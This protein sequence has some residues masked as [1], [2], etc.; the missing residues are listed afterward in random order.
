MKHP[1]NTLEQ[2]LENFTKAWADKDMHA[3]SQCLSDDI[4]YKASIGPNLGET[5]YGKDDVLAG[6]IKIIAYDDADREISPPVICDNKAFHTWVYTS[7]TTGKVIAKGCDIFHFK[8]GLICIKDA[9][10]KVS[11]TS[12]T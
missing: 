8:N 4:I 11:L 10:R 6:I 3:L 7:K 9:Y 2:C 5:W 12:D 1:H